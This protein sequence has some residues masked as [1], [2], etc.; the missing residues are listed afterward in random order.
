MHI[1][2]LAFQHNDLISSDEDCRNKYVS[3]I[4][5]RRLAK[6]GKLSTFGFAEG[7]SCTAPKPNASFHLWCDDPRP[8]SS[9]VDEFNETVSVIDWELTRSAPTQFI[10]DPPW[11][12]LLDVPEMWS[13]G[14]NDWTKKFEQRLETW[15]SSMEM[16]EAAAGY[17]VLPFNL[18]E[19]M[20]ESWT[21]G[22]FWLS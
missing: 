6:E 5:F 9:L 4:L 21:T 19:Y 22:R 16:A 10:L 3:Q 8:N 13:A 12:L 14:M 18:S 1:A 15:I 2:Q 17:N 20:R 11:W 7:A